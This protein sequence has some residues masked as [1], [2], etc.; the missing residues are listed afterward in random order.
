MGEWLSRARRHRFL[1]QSII[2]IAMS[3]LLS[4]VVFCQSGGAMVHNFEVMEEE[5]IGSGACCMDVNESGAFLLG[6]TSDDSAR[7]R[8]HVNIYRDNGEYETGISFVCNGQFWSLFEGEDIWLYFVRE[9]GL[10]RVNR[11][12][13]V[14]EQM[15]YTGSPNEIYEAFDRGYEFQTDQGVYTYEEWYVIPL[16][17]TQC[18]F[19]VKRTDQ[20]GGEQILLQRTTRR[21]WEN[22]LLVWAL[23]MGYFGGIAWILI[24]VCRYYIEQRK[25]Q[26]EDNL[27]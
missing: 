19:V 18:E 22:K 8:M 14:V 12:G 10:Y 16:P 24:Q 9:K 3:L 15:T 27:I 7:R 2:V 5:A 23:R 20:F 26:K 13:E 21:M 4:E 25:K 1:L 17:D 6:F 11:K